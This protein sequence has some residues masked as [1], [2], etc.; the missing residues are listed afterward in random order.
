LIREELGFDG[1]VTSDCMEMKAID[2]HY[3]VAD[4]TVRA[5]NAGIDVILFSHTA[6]KQAAAY[7]HLLAAVKRGDVSEAVVDAANARIAQLKARFPTKKP[8]ITTVYSTAHQQVVNDAARASVTLLRSEPGVLPLH[9]DDS[10]RIA[11][12]EI[13]SQRDSLVQDDDGHSPLSRLMIVQLPNVRCETLSFNAD[14]KGVDELLA[15]GVDVLILATRNAQMVEWQAD[16]V[17]ELSRRGPR[18]ILLAL[19]NP[20]DAGL[21]EGGT[22]I[23]TAGDSRPS[24]MAAVDALTGQFIPTGRLPVEV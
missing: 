24:F 16:R 2:D 7:D 22:V 18:V 15:T 12:V 3:G 5:A 17:R 23:C 21:I 20:Y 1:V 8:D 19:R 6:D 11:L 14:M 10:R 4:S 9:A 13:A